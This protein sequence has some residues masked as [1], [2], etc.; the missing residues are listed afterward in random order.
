MNPE[1]QRLAPDKRGRSLNPRDI[2]IGVFVPCLA[3]CFSYLLFAFKFRWD[4]FW[5]AVLM[6]PVLSFFV[7]FMVTVYAW[8]RFKKAQSVRV[9]IALAISLWGA[10]IWGL[11]RSDRAFWMYMSNYYSFQDLDTYVNIDPATDKG[12]TYMD[13]GQVYFKE[14]TFVAKTKAV[15]FQNHGI[16]CAAP[17]VR[18]PLENQ[19]GASAVEDLGNFIV[20]KSGT[21]DFWAVGIDCCDPTG[22][23]FHCDQGGTLARAGLRML[24]DDVRPFFV[25]AVQ[26]WAAGIGLP[27]RHPLFFYW[28]QD[29]LVEVAG[30]S[31]NGWMAFGTDSLFFSMINMVANIFLQIFLF[32]LG[33]P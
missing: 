9:F 10:S 12:Q 1:M 6:G 25:L 13:A 15:A 26:E 17:I 3:F 23:N 30:Y 11:L 32:K 24:R 4:H 22:E 28:V 31:H 20:P 8:R 18:Q 27:V 29:P 21:I 19:G 5:P 7:S 16:Y 2:F 14:S 33:L